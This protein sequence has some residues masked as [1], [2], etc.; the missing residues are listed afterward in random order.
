[1]NQ[2]AVLSTNSARAIGIQLQMMAFNSSLHKQKLTKTG[3]ATSIWAQIIKLLEENI[4]I[5]L[6]SL[7][8]DN[9]FLH[10]DRL[11]WMMS[12]S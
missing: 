4:G 10:I 2:N 1:M 11:Q 3:S 6:H 7:E 12:D 9:R 8:F 5:S